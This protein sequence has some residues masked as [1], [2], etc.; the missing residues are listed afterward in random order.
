MIHSI[1][2][3]V[4]TLSLLLTIASGFVPVNAALITHNGYMLNTNTNIVTGGGLEWLQWDVTLGMSISDALTNV[5]GTFD[6]GRLDSCNQ[7]ASLSA[8]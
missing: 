6:G 8:F 5:A 7:H 4:F 1:G 2:S 3:K